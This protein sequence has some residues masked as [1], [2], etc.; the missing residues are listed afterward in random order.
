MA[1]ASRKPVV[2]LLSLAIAMA[3]TVFLLSAWP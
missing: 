2:L 1:A 3:F